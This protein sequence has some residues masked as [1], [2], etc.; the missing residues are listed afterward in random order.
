MGR[1]LLKPGKAVGAGEVDVPVSRG[2]NSLR[3]LQ[4][5][6]RSAYVGNTAAELFGELKGCRWRPTYC[7]SERTVRMD[8]TVYRNRSDIDDFGE[9]PHNDSWTKSPGPVAVTCRNVRE[10]LMRRL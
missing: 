7:P 1:Q 10:K 2:S 3:Q 9:V 6:P 4:T 8:C 5:P